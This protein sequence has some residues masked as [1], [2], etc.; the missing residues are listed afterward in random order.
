MLYVGGNQNP[1]YDRRYRSGTEMGLQSVVVGVDGSPASDRALGWIASQ[2]TSPE[3]H[4]HAV[5][6][7]SVNAEWALMAVP[8]DTTPWLAELEELVRSDWVKAAEGSPA[9]VDGRVVEAPPADAL[10]QVAE[11]EDADAIVVGYQG[12]TRWSRHHLGGT[13]SKLLHRSPRPVIIAGEATR[14]EPMASRIVVGCEKPDSAV[15]LLNWA[16]DVAEPRGLP[17]AA[18]HVVE[19]L[20]WIDTYYPVDM[21]AVKQAARERFEEVLGEIRSNREVAVELTSEAR[22]GSALTELTDATEGA[23]LLVVGSHHHGALGDFLSG[24][25]T[26]HTPLLAHC[27]VAVIPFS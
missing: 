12:Q 7:Y 13:A 6:G 10:I 26:S 25:I 2:M 1:R 14:V 8:F 22:V 15:R 23:D 24:S 21:V 20:A 9:A 19:P 18:V 4:I 3:D 17:V 27:P 16:L 5:H 11:S